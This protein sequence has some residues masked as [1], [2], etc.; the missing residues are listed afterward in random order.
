MPT[1]GGVTIRVSEDHSRV[2]ELGERLDG[3]DVARVEE[4]L[5]PKACVEQM[6]DRML[7]AADVGVDRHPLPLDLA[8]PRFAIVRRVEETEIVPTR[9]G[10]L[11]HG[12]RLAPGGAAAL[13]TRGADPILDRRERALAG[14]RR[15]EALD[16]WQENG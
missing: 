14:S 10:P 5:V 3:R 4:H 8:I 1:F 15:L 7:G 13:R 2:S 11:R 12:V 9:P 16:G 6:Q